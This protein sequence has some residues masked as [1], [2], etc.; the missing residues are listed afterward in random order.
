MMAYGIVCQKISVAQQYLCTSYSGVPSPVECRSRKRAIRY[1]HQ[2]QGR[3]G[4][5]PH[6][7]A[8]AARPAHE[9]SEW[10]PVGGLLC[11]A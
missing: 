2:P 10:R 1:R 3:Q 4:A 8:Y 11:G 5:R 6:C 9:L 7:R